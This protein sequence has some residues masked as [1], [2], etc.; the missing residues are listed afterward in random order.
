MPTVKINYSKIVK[1]LINN[2]FLKNTKILI[3]NKFWKNKNNFH[4]ELI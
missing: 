2:K 4:N 1:I 3:N